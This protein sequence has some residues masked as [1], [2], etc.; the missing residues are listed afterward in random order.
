MRVD[1]RQSAL[2]LQT[3]ELGGAIC[4]SAIGEV[5]LANAEMLAKALDEAISRG[6]DVVL[7]D[8]TQMRFI[9][10][11]GLNVLL[12]ATNRLREK[13]HE[14]RLVVSE[15]SHPARVIRLGRFDAVMPVFTSREDAL[16]Q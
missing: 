5:D 13:S 7:L 15:T 10:S 11:A 14:L 16:R 8:M 12:G 3:E 9:D 1:V 4:V 2:T 6:T